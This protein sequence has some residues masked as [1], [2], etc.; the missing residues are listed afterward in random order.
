MYV[1]KRNSTKFSS[2]LVLTFSKQDTVKA[3]KHRMALDPNQ[4][5]HVD[6]ISVISKK[7][8]F[9]NIFNVK[10]KSKIYEITKLTPAFSFNETGKFSKKNRHIPFQSYVMLNVFYVAVTPQR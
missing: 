10:I 6:A 1:V 4:R 9:S 7:R 3:N 5:L 2:S 8:V